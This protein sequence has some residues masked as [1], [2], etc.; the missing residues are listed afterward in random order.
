[1]FGYHSM[2][3][4][5]WITCSVADIAAPIKNA[6]VGGPFGSNL[7]SHDYVPFGVPV[8]RGQNMNHGR[9]VGGDFV[10]VS[11]TKAEELSANTA[12]PDDLV[13]TQRGTLG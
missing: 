2:E 9:W 13:F 1:M 7:V 4:N 8:I 3:D 10:Y 5:G 6:L 11:Y 12:R